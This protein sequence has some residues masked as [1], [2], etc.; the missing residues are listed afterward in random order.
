MRIASVPPDGSRGT[1]ASPVSFEHIYDQWFHRVSRWVLA[2]G[3]PRSDHEDVVQDVFA[4]AYRQLHLFDG[5]NIAG[6]LYQIAWRKA[7]DYRQLAWVQHVSV[8]GARALFDAARHE[9]PGPLDNLETKQKSELLRRRLDK[10]PSEQRAAFTW[11][12]LEGCSGH[13]IA[14]RQQVPL[15]T[16]WV[17]LHTAR[18]KVMGRTT[19][20]KRQNPARGAR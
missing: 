16:V 18:Q 12:E 20:A 6:W 8:S 3:A 9:G 11:F 1:N 2:L 5:N 10:L 15:N 17:R 13:E 19:P 4:I 7:R 14:E